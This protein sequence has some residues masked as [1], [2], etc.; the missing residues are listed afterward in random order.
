MVSVVTADAQT[1]GPGPAG[2]HLAV[3]ARQPLPLGPA[4]PSRRPT[5]WAC[6]ARWREWRCARRLAALGVDARLKWP[7]D[8]LVGERKL[9]GILAEAS[10]RRRPASSASWWASASTCS[11][12]RRALP[13]GA[14]SL[15]RETGRVRCRSRSPRRRSWRQMSV[16]YHR[17]RRGARGRAP[18]RVARALG[19]RGGAAASR[20]SAGERVVRGVALDIDDDGALLLARDGAGRERIV[21]G[22]VSPVRASTR[23]M[24]LLLTVDAG[25][26][27]TVLGST[28]ARPCRRSGG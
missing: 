11:I 14:T 10:S 16:W 12:P 9:A 21:S 13:A 3:A 28:T 27:N 2:P 19:A 6:S 17:A 20:S 8:V 25:N 1:R 23:S 22:E 5:R 15:R 24:S 4:A 7:N 18:G 26:T